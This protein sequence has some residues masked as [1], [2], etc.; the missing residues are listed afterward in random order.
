LKIG[1]FMDALPCP[2]RD[3]TP[4]V[5]RS[6]QRPSALPAWRRLL[7]RTLACRRCHFVK[8]QE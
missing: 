3:E 5:P 4:L 8:R 1:N 6:Q 2:K 7:H